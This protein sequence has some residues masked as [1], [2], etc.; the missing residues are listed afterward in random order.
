[1][2]ETKL[3][4]DRC[5]H[6][7]SQ[8]FK[9]NVV[10]GQFLDQPDKPMTLKISKSTKT[11]PDIK[12]RA[13]S[14]VPGTNNKE[15]KEHRNFQWLGWWGGA[16]SQV[17]R[18]KDV[19]TGPMSGCWIV[20]YRRNGIMYVGRIGKN[21]DNKEQT[22]AVVAGWNNWAQANPDSII[23]GSIRSGTG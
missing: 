8:W 20:V 14:M 22:T 1:M 23:C 13:S 17:P 7:P 15:S 12:V 2:L 10:N 4:V 19:L 9:L 3:I 18:H 5:I 21:K 6:L 11:A 16:I